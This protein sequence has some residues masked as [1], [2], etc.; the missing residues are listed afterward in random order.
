MK[1]IRVSFG[2][3]IMSYATVE[4]AMDSITALYR[5]FYVHNPFDDWE[6][7]EAS[8]KLYEIEKWLNKALEQDKPSRRKLAD[9]AINAN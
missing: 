6:D 7:I 3:R 5:T 9:I 8:R 2:C 1:R 4:G